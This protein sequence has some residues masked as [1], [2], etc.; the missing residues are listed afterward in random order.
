MGLSALFV[1]LKR[2][3]E[4]APMGHYLL[5]GFFLLHLRKIFFFSITCKM[6]RHSLQYKRTSK[7][8]FSL[9]FLV[10]GALSPA[11]AAAPP[12]E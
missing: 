7:L 8:L 4:E 11:M 6:S 3:V 1:L 10:L 12:C 5:K 2:A 9:C